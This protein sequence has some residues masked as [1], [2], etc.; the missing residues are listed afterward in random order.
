MD[1]GTRYYEAAKE[2]QKWK[3]IS[4]L[5]SDPRTRSDD[6]PVSSVS[7]SGPQI[8]LGNPLNERNEKWIGSRAEHLPRMTSAEYGFEEQETGA[9]SQSDSLTAV[10]NDDS[11]SIGER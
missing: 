10:A 5:L 9:E 1:V 2:I 3:N 11:L 4:G 6:D 8:I 7:S